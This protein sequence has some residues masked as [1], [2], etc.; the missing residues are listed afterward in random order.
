MRGTGTPLTLIVASWCRDVFST[1]ACAAFHTSPVFGNVCAGGFGAGLQLTHTDWGL[2]H[3]QRFWLAPVSSCQRRSAW[4]GV[5][6][7]VA[8]SR[9]VT[10]FARMRCGVQVCVRSPGRLTDWGWLNH[11]LKGLLR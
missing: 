7:L 5:S 6:P 11:P 2:A 4:R 9:V 8:L 3:F 10:A 1:A